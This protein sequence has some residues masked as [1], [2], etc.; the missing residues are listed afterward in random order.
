MIIVVTSKSQERGT[1]VPFLT[2]ACVLQ[3]CV[4]RYMS[5]RAQ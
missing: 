3:N 1:F 5:Q 2:I 4:S